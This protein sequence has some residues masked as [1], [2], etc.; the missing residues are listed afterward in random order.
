MSERAKHPL[1]GDV[2]GICALVLAFVVIGVLLH[3]HRDEFAGKSKTKLQEMHAVL[4]Q[5]ISVAEKNLKQREREGWRGSEL[6]RNSPEERKSLAEIESAIERD[7][8]RLKQEGE[9]LAGNRKRIAEWHAAMAELSRH[10]E[11]EYMEHLPEL[12][13][14]LADLESAIERSSD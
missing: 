7:W 13:K 11:W 5:K 4:Q 6:W 1:K 14:R 2:I 3:Q 12:Q 9:H 10:E 8:Q